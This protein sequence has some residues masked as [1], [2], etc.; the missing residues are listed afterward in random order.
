M[1]PQSSNVLLRLVSLQ[2]RL[3]KSLFLVTMLFVV[4]SAGLAELTLLLDERLDKLPSRL[5]ATVD[6]ARS[7]LSVVAAHPWPFHPVE[8]APGHMPRERRLEPRLI[9]RFTAAETT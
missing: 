2:D 5:T 7:V 9:V 1:D 8:L 4:G 6:S 3:R